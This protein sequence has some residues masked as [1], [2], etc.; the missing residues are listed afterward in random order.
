MRHN[1][2]DDVYVVSFAVSTTDEVKRIRD[3]TF[4]LPWEET[5]SCTKLQKLTVREHHK[6]PEHF[7][8][9]IKDSVAKNECDG[10]VLGGEDGSC[11]YNQF[12]TASY[13]QLSDSADYIYRRVSDDKVKWSAPYVGFTHY[14]E[15]LLHG[16][17]ELEHGKRR[18]PVRSKMLHKL[19]TDLKFLFERSFKKTIVHAPF[20]YDD[21]KHGR[22]TL[23]GNYTVSVTDLE[24]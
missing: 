22:L 18:D 9:S 5:L 8:E 17:Y 15:N 12:P 23:E 24:V 7:G 1:V 13:Q 10:Y 20:E 19:Y 2:G 11:W 6:V 21:P 4:F 16:I 14:M 3:T